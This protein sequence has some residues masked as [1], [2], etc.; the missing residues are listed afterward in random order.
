MRGRVHKFGDHINTDLIMPARYLNNPREERVKHCM[1]GVD[2]DFQKKA[3]K[4]DIIV[5]GENFGCGSSRE[6]APRAIIDL[7]IACIIAESFDYIFY[8]NCLNLAFP[9]LMSKE[10]YEKTS[11]GDILEIDF[12][13]GEIKNITSGEMFQVEPP[14]SCQLELFQ[15]GGLIEYT[16]R[17]LLK[18]RSS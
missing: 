17:K 7:G 12:I 1:E 14:S 18:G 5:A 8:D 2:S 13:K 11:E 6:H 10:V 9:V 3:E 4:G 15:M 16:R